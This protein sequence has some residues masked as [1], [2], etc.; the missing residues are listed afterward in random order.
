MIPQS[1]I[2]AAF[3]SLPSHHYLRTMALLTQPDSCTQ[4]FIVLT[5]RHQHKSNQ[6]LLIL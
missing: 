1:A 4:L 2:H 3:E 5:R 6:T